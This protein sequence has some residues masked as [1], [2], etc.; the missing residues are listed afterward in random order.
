MSNKSGFICR[1]QAEVVNLSF[2]QHSD[3]YDF[4]RDRP[5]RNQK[6]E[7][8]AQKEIYREVSYEDTM[9]ETWVKA[10]ERSLDLT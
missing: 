1:W 6:A 3:S 4:Y 9:V 7:G 10:E 5:F 8:L 2:W